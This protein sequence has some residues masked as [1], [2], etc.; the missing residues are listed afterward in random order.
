MPVLGW[1]HAE[2][3]AKRAREVWLI[4]EAAFDGDLRKRQL[5]GGDEPSRS[6]QAESHDELMRR[7]TKRRPEE[8][9][10]VKWTDVCTLSEGNQRHIFV[11]L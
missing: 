10:K 1:R 7:Q 5:S 2:Y 8:P 11:E 6:L 4:V 9:C 3:S